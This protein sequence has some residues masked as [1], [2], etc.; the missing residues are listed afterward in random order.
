MSFWSLPITL[1]VLPYLLAENNVPSLCC[2]FS[3]LSL[4]SAMFLE[5]LIPFKGEWYLE[6]MIWT[7]VVAGVLWAIGVI[8][9]H[10]LP[11][12]AKQG[13]HVYAQIHVH[14]YISLYFCIKMYWKLWVLTD[15]SNSSSEEFILLFPFSTVQPWTTWGLGTLNPCAVETLHITLDSPKM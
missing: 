9:A 4:E 10:K 13:A 5:A 2:I 3:A 14:A 7:R 15:I 8:L 12:W 11:P 6:T 1:R